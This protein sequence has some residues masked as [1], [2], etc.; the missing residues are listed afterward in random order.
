M[1]PS[2]Q[3]LLVCLNEYLLLDASELC[4]NQMLHKDQSRHVVEKSNAVSVLKKIKLRGYVDVA[5]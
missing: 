1:V 5:R 4:Y 2:P 3:D